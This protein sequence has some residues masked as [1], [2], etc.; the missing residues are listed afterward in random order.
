MIGIGLMLLGFA[1]NVIIASIVFGFVGLSGGMANI[2]I[3]A[4]IQSRTDSHMLGRVMALVMFTVSVIEPLSLALAGLV[5]DFNVTLMFA[6]AGAI[7][8]AAS[9][10]SLASR[11]LR[12]AD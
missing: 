3:L 12:T 9:A 4:W 5:A 8:L 1:P 7:L 11:T 2:I 10:L 6:A